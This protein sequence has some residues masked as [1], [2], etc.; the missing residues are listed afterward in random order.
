[1]KKNLCLLSFSFML[2]PV[3]IKMYDGI[4]FTSIFTI[5][6]IN[7]ES[8]CCSSFNGEQTLHQDCVTKLCGELSKPVIE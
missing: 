2:S 4:P 8:F 7:C 3:V 5:K 1:M 6:E